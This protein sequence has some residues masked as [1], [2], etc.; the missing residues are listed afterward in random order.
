[1]NKFSYSKKVFYYLLF[2]LVFVHLATKLLII[3]DQG[4]K[5]DEGFMAFYCQQPLSELLNYLYTSKEPNPPLIFIICHFW[6]K[7]F[8]IGLVAMKTLPL[9]I[10]TFTLIFLATLVKK[11]A[12]NIIVLFV[13]TL[14]LFAN[15][16]LHFAYEVKGFGLVLCL[17]IL[18]YLLFITYLKN[19]KNWP[20][21]L[22]GLVNFL[23]VMTHYNAAL[24]IVFQ[25]FCYLLYWK[26]NK[27][28]VIK[29]FFV[30][31]VA[32]LLFLPQLIYFIE[33]LN[34]ST[35]WQP[36]GSWERFHYI[37]QKLTANDF[38]YLYFLLP[39]YLSPILVYILQLTHLLNTNFKWK[40]F[41][42]FWGLTFIP[43][44]MNFVFSLFVPA[45]ELVYLYYLSFS[46]L[47]CI[48]Y[49]V[50]SIKHIPIQ[51]ALAGFFIFLNIKQYTHQTTPSPRWDEFVHFYNTT[52]S[53]GTN[54]MVVC[55]PYKSKEVLYHINLEGFKNYTDFY[56]EL[57]KNNIIP[58]AGLTNDS[59]PISINDGDAIYYLQNHDGVID[60]EKK[61]LK[62]F[63]KQFYEQSYY[64]PDQ[65]LSI[66]K[67]TLKN[68]FSYT[69]DTLTILNRDW[70]KHTTSAQYNSSSP[71]KYELINKK[72]INN[73]FDAEL[74]IPNQQ[75][76]YII[77]HATINNPND[78]SVVY[79]MEKEG[80]IIYNQSFPAQENINGLT[81]GVPSSIK[82]AKPDI[83]SIYLHNPTKK[84]AL[85]TNYAI[86]LY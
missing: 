68:P 59:I 60:P 40:R 54:Y 11:I 50:Y 5:G 86:T 1:M 28:Q 4:L 39:I 48:G 61:I 62:Q 21:F 3:G 66:N 30:N 79:K 53:S 55:A 26:T 45:F 29:L 76:S 2:A 52:A 9:L 42:I 41:F 44:L 82:N 32:F 77:I 23:I 56:G 71:V 58:I 27:R 51:I 10:S 20:L 47:V 57:A 38:Y 36:L 49:V 43:L 64:K 63:S 22:L 35:S 34:S 15:I 31:L 18:S 25:A 37:Q 67:F 8:G 19:N 84:E 85:L 81:F 46:Y 80:E 16:H 13:T 78:I 24:G 75:F 83:I 7:A 72:L 6:F 65:E 74:K 69:Q 70:S 17:S 12:S 73:E 33:N 14:Y